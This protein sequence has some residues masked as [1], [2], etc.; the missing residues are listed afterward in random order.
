MK[1]VNISRIIEGKEMCPNILESMLMTELTIL[2]SVSEYVSLKLREWKEWITL[3]I[4]LNKEANFPR[5]SFFF[6]DHSEDLCGAKI[7]LD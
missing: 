5:G 2:T 3:T 1:V 4:S 7:K 6:L